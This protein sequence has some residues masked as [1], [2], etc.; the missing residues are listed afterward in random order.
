[1]LSTRDRQNEPVGSIVS[2]HHVTRAR[3]VQRGGSF[4]SGIGAETE[5]KT[6]AKNPFRRLSNRWFGKRPPRK[7]DIRQ[8]YDVGQV[9]RTD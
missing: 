5:P 1:M 7:A 4:R 9:P 6:P 2:R 8:N 3:G